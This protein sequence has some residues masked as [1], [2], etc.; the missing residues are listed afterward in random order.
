MKTILVPTDFSEN[1]KNA[2]HFAAEL[3]VKNGATLE[4]MHTNT[5]AAYMPLMPEMYTAQESAVEQYSETIETDIQALASGLLRTK[6]FEGLILKT[7]VGEGFL[8]LAINAMIE[9]DGCDLVVMGTQGATGATEFF[10][11]SNTEKVIR[12]AKCPVLVIP[13]DAKA[14]SLGTVVLSSTLK[15]DQSKAFAELAGWQRVMDFGVKILYLNDPGNFG[16][17]EEIKLAAQKLCDAAGLKNTEVFSSSNT[18][19]EEKAILKFAEDMD[20]D[21]IAMGTHQRQGLSHMIF[22][23]LTEDTANHST[24]PVLCVP[25]G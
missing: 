9:A 24:I 6:G 16:S 19:N 23:S 7:R 21:M 3:A 11:G 4:I 25:L 12:S 14:I 13:K 5:A 10:V 15:E 18:F 8:H 1:A 17:N 20:A 2:L 22:G